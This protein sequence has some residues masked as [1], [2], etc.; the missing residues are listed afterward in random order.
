MLINQF[1]KGFRLACVQLAVTADKAANI[2]RATKFIAAAAKNGAKIVVLPEC[3]NSPYG[4]QYF[5]DYSEKIPGETTTTL[6]QAAKE[7]NV[8]IIGGSIP[9]ECGGK[10]YNTLTAFNPQGEM[11]AKHRK[12]HLFDIDVPGK[13]RFQE[14]EVLAPGNNLTM[15]DTPYCKI[16]LGICYDIRFAEMA[17]VYANSGCKLLVYPGAFNM[18]TGPAHWELLARA[19]AVDSQLYVCSVSPAR[20]ETATYTAWGHTLIS[21]PWGALMGEAKEKEEIVYADIDLNYLDEVR[22]AIPVT[23]QR[24]EDVY[25]MSKAL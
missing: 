17:R 8:H 13:I 2:T 7:N 21:N 5:K 22:D 11:I 19:R 15:C 23:K 18:T 14:S 24:R 4:T 3:F 10:L 1:K 9:E 12:V 16:G 20:D 6:A 25:T